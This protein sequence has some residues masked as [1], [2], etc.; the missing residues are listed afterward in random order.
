MVVRQ[1]CSLTKV[2]LKSQ[3]TVR[4]GHRKTDVHKGSQ[5]VYKDEC[6][7]NLSARATY[8]QDDAL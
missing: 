1:C 6:V 8:G 4:F 5:C 2:G 7:C 3:N